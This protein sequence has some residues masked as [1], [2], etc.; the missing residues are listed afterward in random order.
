MWMQP[1]CGE[2]IPKASGENAKESSGNPL[3]KSD[4]SGKASSMNIG[5]HDD[6]VFDWHE[7]R[8]W[9][10]HYLNL[11]AAMKWRYSSLYKESS[12]WRWWNRYKHWAHE[13]TAPITVEVLTHNT[14]A[15]NSNGIDLCFK[16]AFIFIYECLSQLTSDTDGL[17]ALQGYFN[18]QIVQHAC[19]ILCSL[20]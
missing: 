15:H 2:R 9:F 8:G 20:E 5:I 14:R 19:S 13:M 6:V 17:V 10:P 18:L 12:A 1:R 16:V 7:E 4:A 11:H 3:G